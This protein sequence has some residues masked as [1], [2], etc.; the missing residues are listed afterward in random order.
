MLPETYSLVPLWSQALPGVP[1]GLSL[2]REKGWLLAWDR[3]Q[4]IYLLNQ[5]G[6]IQAQ[7]R[8]AGTLAQ[9]AVA[10]DGSGAVAIGRGGELRW[11]APDLTTR[12]EQ[13]LDKPLAAAAVDPFGN[14]LVIADAKGGSYFLDGS[15]NV[16]AQSQCPRPLQH[17]A[18][19]AGLPLIVGC[20]DYGLIG[21]FDQTLNWRWRETLVVN[22]GSLSVNGDGSSL[23]LACFSDGLHQFGADG[24]AQARLATPEPCRL[25]AQ[26]FEGERIVV[27]GMTHNIFCLERGGQVSCRHTFDSPPAAVAASPR[28]EAMFVALQGGSII[29]LRVKRM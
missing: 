27:A 20:A 17:I 10:D 29:K 6:Q 3:N 13:T 28:G 26:S 1:C 21:A 23:L 15:G 18:F 24:K 19:I 9:C 8:F 7:T 16:L 2:A 22:I 14:F 25:V 4:W 11:Y 12:W 5:A